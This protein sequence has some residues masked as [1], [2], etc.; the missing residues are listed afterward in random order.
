MNTNCLKNPCKFIQENLIILISFF[1]CTVFL[2]TDLGFNITIY[3]GI[4]ALIT[5]LAFVY[6]FFKDRHKIIL[7]NKWPILIMLGITYIT[8]LN[9]FDLADRTKI[10]YLIM[11]FIAAMLVSI[12]EISYKQYEIVKKIFLIAGGVI[13]TLIYF[14]FFAPNLYEK[15]VLPMLTTDA[16]NEVRRLLEEGYSICVNSD[17][18]YTLLIIIFALFFLLFDEINKPHPFIIIYMVGGI[19]ISQRRTELIFTI[20]TIF[21]VYLIYIT[22]VEKEFLQRHKKI[23]FSLVAFSSVILVVGILVFIFIPEDLDSSNRIVMTIY[24][25][26]YHGDVLNGRG[27]LYNLAIEM[28]KT[29]PIWGIGWMNFSKYAAL[30]G[31][32]LVRNIH[33]VYLQLILEC[34]IVGAVIYIL[35]GIF[36]VKKI[37]EVVKSSNGSKESLISLAIVLYFC[38]AGTI[39]NS[40]YYPYFWIF[41]GIAVSICNVKKIIDAEEKE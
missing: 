37:I 34:G 28:I 23:V 18:A 12:T 17:I 7:T 24:D 9:G 11:S 27:V 6:I 22:L 15:I 33:C 36:L 13:S 20:A 21:L 2:I 5:G 16:A 29:D 38:L 30:T 1:S 3:A 32:T 4:F 31:N 26:R 40:V 25:L 39:D 41:L 19:L 35:C 8:S 14:N 10:Y